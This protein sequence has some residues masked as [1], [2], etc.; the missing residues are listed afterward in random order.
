M[1]TGSSNALFEVLDFTEDNLAQALSNEHTSVDYIKRGKYHYHFLLE[2]LRYNNIRNY[3]VKTILIENQYISHSYL[4]DLGSE[5]IYSTQNYSK[6]CKRIHFFSKPFTTI[7]D[8]T[9]GSDKKEEIWSSYRGFVTVKPLPR[10]RLGPILLEPY[11]ATK[12]KNRKFTALRSYTIHLLGKSINLESLAFMEQDGIL[13]ACSTVS[14]WSA[15]H[16]LHTMFNVGILR[17]VMINNLAKYTAHNQPGALPGMGMDLHQI[18]GVIEQIGLK[19]ELRTFNGNATGNQQVEEQNETKDRQ[20]T[21]RFIYAYLRMGLPILLGL[22]FQNRG[23]HLVTL[24]GYEAVNRD[25]IDWVKDSNLPFTHAD[26]IQLLYAH[27]DQVGPFSRIKLTGQGNQAKT[28]RWKDQFTNLVSHDSE[29]YSIIVP[30]SKDIRLTFEDIYKQVLYFE[31][32]FYELIETNQRFVWD[33]YLCHTNDYRKEIQLPNS[34]YSDDQQYKILTDF[35]PPYLWV[36]RAEVEEFPE[37]EF[38]FDATAI[39]YSSDF[40][41]TILFFDEVLKNLLTEAFGDEID[42]DRDTLR[43]ISGM[44]QLLNES[45]DLSFIWSFLRNSLITSTSNDHS[46]P[47]SPPYSSPQNESIKC[48]AKGAAKEAEPTDNSGYQDNPLEMPANENEEIGGTSSQNISLKKEQWLTQ[49]AQGEIEPVLAGV[50]VFVKGSEQHAD[51]INV[52]TALISRYN[53]LKRDQITGNLDYSQYG[54]ELNKITNALLDFIDI[55]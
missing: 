18:C 5:Y 29:V 45:F 27:D 36:A 31:S 16:R 9:Q 50:Q 14:I 34:I 54:A 6:Y 12:S 25:K 32:L 8:L 13:S 24:T 33:I 1:I 22:E 7:E 42:G 51:Q 21:R 41:T 47:S 46:E 40:C 48:E 10:S 2:H 4:S 38:I 43:H 49:I 37:L 28:S 39:P 11:P 15:L 44:N 30:L 55:L 52:I 26:H 17:P 20:F 19:A 23:K 35:L 3:V 53:R